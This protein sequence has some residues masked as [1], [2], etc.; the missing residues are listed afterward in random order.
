VHDPKL[1]PD[2]VK[3]MRE[4]LGAEADL[5]FN[6]LVETPPVSVRLN[7]FKQTSDSETQLSILN[8]PF[9]IH[10]KVAWCED[11]YYL[12]E[13]P[14]FIYDP[15]FHAGTYYVQEASSMFA[16]E[17]A[18]VLLKSFN[19]PLVLDAAAAPGGK[20][21]H[22]LSVLNGRGCLISNEV[23]PQRNSVLQ[24]NIWKWGMSNNVITQQQLAEF[25]NAGE[26]FDLILLDAPCSGEGLF[27]R[28]PDA[29]AEWSLQSVTGC[30]LRQRQLIDDVIPALKVG[31]YLIYS[32][33]TYA[34]EEN[35]ATV[36]QAI[37]KYGLEK[38]KVNAPDGVVDTKHGFQFYPHRVRGEGFFMS[39]LQ[40][41][42]AGAPNISTKAF[43]KKQAAQ[44]VKSP[45]EAFGFDKEG[46]EFY[47]MNNVVYAVPAFAASQLL[48]LQMFNLKSIGTP[49]IEQTEFRSIPHAALALHSAYNFHQAADLTNETALSYLCGDA[50]ANESDIKQGYA[51]ARFNGLNLGWMK[52]APNRFNNLYPHPWRIRKRR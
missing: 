1:P 22:L 13:R 46:F 40:K 41:T 43:S 14:A 50:L 36:E 33:C 6:A 15:M 49:L 30:S 9:S 35:D 26:T 34:I 11:G 23:M 20:S 17:V 31:G 28:D 10:S 8:S 45:A 48:S 32:T 19:D 2:F 51:L 18:R 47:S 24:E 21:T 7:P 27:R 16:G 5:F 39:V 52:A 12:T 29:C 38:I 3:R 44:K 4:Q 37:E 25:G 42:H